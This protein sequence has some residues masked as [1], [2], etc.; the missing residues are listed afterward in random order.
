MTMPSSG[1][2]SRI[3][4]GSTS[5]PR[6]D[7]G[8][9]AKMKWLPARD[10]EGVPRA[11][12]LTSFNF[13]LLAIAPSDISPAVASP[14][15][16]DPAPRARRAAAPCGNGVP[17]LLAA[18][19]A[20]FFLSFFRE[21]SFPLDSESAGEPA[22]LISFVLIEI[23]RIPYRATPWVLCRIIA[24][25]YVLLIPLDE[26]FLGCFTELSSQFIFFVLF[27]QLLINLLLVT[28][29]KQVGTELLSSDAV[30]GILGILVIVVPLKHRS[31][32]IV[33]ELVTREINIVMIKFL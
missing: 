18:A 2:L 23:W 30:F 19:D 12:W 10:A 32:I 29:S 24:F 11:L 15:L 22:L 14:S 8:E 6:G 21:D 20:A 13:F 4:D 5:D 9:A 7:P 31:L 1:I 3:S 33:L 27:M 28:I 26:R 25:V 17:D 16:P